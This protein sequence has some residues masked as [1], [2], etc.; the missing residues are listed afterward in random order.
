VGSGKSKGYG[1]LKGT[2]ESI[3]L[4]TF[5]LDEPSRLAGVAEHPNAEIA[6]W[7]QQRYHLQAVDTVIP[8]PGTKVDQAEPWR[9]S[10]LLTAQEFQDA[11]AAIPFDWRSV[12]LLSER[13]LEAAQ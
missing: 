7:F 12:H 8:L 6:A 4:T 10:R 13:A 9:W 11:A 1:K 3:E 5:G 2:C